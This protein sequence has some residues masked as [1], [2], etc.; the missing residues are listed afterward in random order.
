MDLF[1][2]FGRNVSEL[3]FIEIFE[4]DFDEGIGKIRRKD[5]YNIL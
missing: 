5:M 2:F 4:L 3:V 1:A